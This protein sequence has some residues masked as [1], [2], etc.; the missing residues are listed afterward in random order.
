MTEVKICGIGNLEDAMA[1]CE[2]GADG[3]GFVFYERSPR[4]V[5]P[6]AARD[7]IA[8]LP[9]DVAKIGVFVNEHPAVVGHT[10]TLCGLDF[11]QVHGDES[12]EYCRRIPS[13]LLIKAIRPRGPDDLTGLDDWGARAFLMDSS[14]SGRYGG[15]GKRSDWGMAAR[16]A[17]RYPLI[18]AGGL[19]P[20]NVGAAIR[21]VS[22]AAVDV[23]SGVEKAPGKKDHGKMRAFMEEVRGAKGKSQNI[24]HHEE[25]EGHEGEPWPR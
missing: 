19:D 16:L 24:F 8:Q 4:Y 15:T 20:G 12:I 6:E 9:G 11:I 18:L 1:A 10:F 22:P 3:L 14:E 5:S 13:S 17:R 21:E 2:C 23:G 7:I 25:H